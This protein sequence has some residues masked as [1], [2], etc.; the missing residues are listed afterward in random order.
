MNS[1][2]KTFAIIWTGQLFSILSSAVVGFAIIVW[3]SIE[4]KSAEVLAFSTLAAL[5]P[6]S[7]LGLVSG[8]FVD[9]WNRKLTMI[10]SDSF[11]AVCTLILSVLFFMGTAEI[12]HI[13]ILL[14]LRSF[15]SAFHS[16]AMQASV[17]LLAPEDQLTRVAGINQVIQ[18][19]CSIAGPAL[20]ALMIGL[21]DISYILLLDVA[22]AAI[23][24]FSLLFV[25]IPDP[26]RQDTSKLNIINDLRE[27]WDGVKDIKGLIPLVVFCVLATFFIMPIGALF[28]L[29]T[30]QHFSGNAFQM[31]LIEIAWG[32]GMLLGG[33]IMGI[34]SVKIN[35]VLLI[36]GM[37]LLLGASFFLSGILP[38]DGFWQFA[39]LTLIGGLAGSI[40]N[41]SFVAVVQIKI[42][43]KML[44]RFFSVFG[45]VNLLPA[46]VGLLGTGY[47]A[48]AIGLSSSFVIAGLIICTLGAL[49][50]F[51]S[52][53]IALG[54]FKN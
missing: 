13:Y 10:L 11:I 41:S 44:G 47:V 16:P 29:M 31:S 28:P 5:L 37:Y 23:A 9:R 34:F 27:A 4:T 32:V 39:A 17:P 33:A 54:G 48:D 2:K 42:E 36:N 14:S 1:W 45:S 3:L 25:E 8:V 30:L 38:R 50:Y 35:K 49:S 26:E 22:G 43:P 6:Q 7:V 24:C 12:W 21:F 52:N 40:Y 18:S 53:M 51:F 15:G 19:V 46:M 20:G